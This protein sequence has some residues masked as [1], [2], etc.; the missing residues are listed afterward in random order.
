MPTFDCLLGAFSGLVRTYLALQPQMAHYRVDDGLRREAGASVVQVCDVVHAGRVR[1][2]PRE[3]EI[4]SVSSSLPVRN[5]RRGSRQFGSGPAWVIR[6]TSHST[7]S[8]VMVAG[9]RYSGSRARRKSGRSC[10]VDRPRVTAAT[11]AR[12]GPTCRSPS[13]AAGRAP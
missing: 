12:R 2:R 5:T 13:A 4:H 11:A 7:S 10:G 6:G 9:T 1:P 8:T 3:I